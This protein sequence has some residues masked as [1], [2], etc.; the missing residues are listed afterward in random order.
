MESLSAQLYA[1][2][3]ILLAGLTIGLVVDVYRVIRGILRPGLVSTAILDLMFWALLTPI[4][5]IYLLL[6][7]WGQLRGYVIMG[8]ILGF[9]FYRLTMSRAVVALLLWL[10]DLL[11]RL[12]TFA[13]TV[14]WSII[15]FPIVL[16]QELGLG[17]R[18]LR[19]KTRLRW[20]K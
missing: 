7:N 10:I 8:L 1:F 15:S 4:L 9:A 5:V 2:G 17:V 13:G 20:R 18:S 3:I 12:V 11:G 6:A 16:G 19:L 14:V